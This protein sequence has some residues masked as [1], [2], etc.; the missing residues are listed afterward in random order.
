M[1]GSSKTHRAR[2]ADT[3]LD[4]LLARLSQIWANRLT[5]LAPD[6][7]D[8]SPDAGWTFRQIA[9]LLS[10][11]DLLSAARE[12]SPADDCGAEGHE[13]FVDVVAD[14]LTDAQAAEP[15][16]ERDRAFHDPAVNAQA[17]AVRGTAPGR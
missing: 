1:V 15:V 12:P 13:G 6:Q 16:Q 7:L 11:A 5:K 3:Q 4:G 10:I 8:R 14:F 17:R 2:L 9:F